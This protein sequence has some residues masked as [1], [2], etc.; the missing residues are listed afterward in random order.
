MRDFVT[1]IPDSAPKTIICKNCGLDNEIPWAQESSE[2]FTPVIANDFDSLSNGKVWVPAGIGIPCKRCSA[3]IYFELPR[4]KKTTELHLFGDESYDTGYAVFTYSLTGAD[5]KII[6]EIE[7]KVIKLKSDIMPD[8]DPL[9]WTIHMKD[10]WSSKER[11]K[12]LAFQGWTLANVWSL[13]NDVIEL[14]NLLDNDLFVY[15]I[16]LT[17]RHP[18]NNQNI[19]VAKYNCYT[20]LLLNVIEEA[21]AGGA[22]PKIH[23]DSEKNSLSDRVIYQWARE[24][25]QTAEKQLIYAYLAKGISIPEPQFIKP[26]SHPCS[27]LADFIS[28]WIRRYHVKRQKGEKCEIDIARLGNIT[29]YGFTNTGELL[30]MRQRG[31]PWSEFYERVGKKK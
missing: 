15:S 13:I 17:K 1:H 6:S 29:Y 14:I 4:K 16:T 7:K 25:F 19:N 26:A 20:M 11:S 2:S 10:L 21:T 22:Q 3:Q 8:K 31:F 30:R 18:F 5:F 9:T 12:S 24:K 28:F 23:F 27:E